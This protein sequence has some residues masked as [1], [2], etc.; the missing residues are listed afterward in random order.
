MRL[1][2]SNLSGADG[3]FLEIVNILVL[4]DAEQIKVQEIYIIEIDNWFSMKWRNFAGKNLV[5]CWLT[6]IRVPA[7]HPNRV[8]G[9]KHFVFNKYYGYREVPVKRRIQHLEKGPYHP[10]TLTKI[11]DISKSAVFAWYSANADSNKAASLMIYQ[12]NRDRVLTWYA[13]FKWNGK[14][15]LYKTQGIDRNKLNTRLELTVD[16]CTD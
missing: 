12:S 4:N 9:E 7:F 15:F 14:W 6:P 16:S 3:A 13:E 2:D 10:P 1:L 5:P 11:Q 8:L